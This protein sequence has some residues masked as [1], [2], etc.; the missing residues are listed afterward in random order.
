MST[1]FRATKIVEHWLLEVDEHSIHSPFF[2]DFYNKVLKAKTAQD[3]SKLE[4]LQTDL[5]SNREKVLLDQPNSKPKKKSLSE[6]T[7]DFALPRQYSALYLRIIKY[8]KAKRIVEIGTSLGITTLYLAEQE[9]AQVYTF[10]ANHA[11]ANIALTNFEYFEKKNVHLIEGKMDVT[12]SNFFQD[13]TKVNFAVIDC[14]VGHDLTLKFFNLLMRRLNE[15]S[16]VVINNI[17]R[18]KET[19]KA[20]TWLKVHELVYGSINL[21][22]CGIL[23]FE[24]SLNKQHFIFSLN[25]N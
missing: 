17:Y 25:K 12:L 16:I 10:E 5:L 21:R 13:T 22:E 3:F 1:F 7:K 4:K 19:E 23:F 14:S 6:I 9:A 20:W 15:K 18:S 11:L 2:F 8:L 24:P